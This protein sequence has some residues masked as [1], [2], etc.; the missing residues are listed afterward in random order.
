MKIYTRMGD[1]GETGLLGGRR[2]PKT[3]PIF[4]LLGSLDET[5]ASIGVAASHLA[6]TKFPLDELHEVQSTILGIG[7][8]IA[9]DQPSVAKILSTLDKLTDQLEQHIDRWDKALPPLKNFILPEGTPGAA[10]LHA[11]RTLARR[12]ERTFHEWPGSTEVVPIG[13]YLNR[14][15]DYLFQA[16]RFANF[17]ANHKEQIWH[18]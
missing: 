14:L 12:T 4:E 3:D 13:R 11:S 16:A 8:C 9:S 5:N 18:Q 17:L 7:A 1:G 2:A 10:T 6:N 15:S